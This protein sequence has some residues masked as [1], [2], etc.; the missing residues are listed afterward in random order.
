[1][2]STNGVTNAAGSARA[3]YIH[4]VDGSGRLI[5]KEHELKFVFL[6]ITVIVGMFCVFVAHAAASS[7]KDEQ[8]ATGQAYIDKSFKTIDSNHDGV[9]SRDE[10]NAFLNQYLEK[11]QAAFDAAFDAADTN[12]DGKLSRAE[13]QAANPPLAKYF[14]QIDIHHRGY[15]TKDDI[16]GAMLKKM[17]SLVD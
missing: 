5:N 13:L 6:V 4:T 2:A 12:H 14:D 7:G 10:W 11:Q 16:R 1:M 15:L 17:D 3:I 9:I 8:T